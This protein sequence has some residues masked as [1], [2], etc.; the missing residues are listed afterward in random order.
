MSP[1][2]KRNKENI[3]L[4][5]RWQFK[6]G[7]YY[8]Q[9]PPGLESEWDGKK[10]FRLGKTQ[11]EAYRTWADRIDHADNQSELISALC[12]RYSMEHVP[13]LAPKSQEGYRPSVARVRAV[14]GSMRVSD[15]TPHHARKYFDRVKAAKSLGVAR[16]DITVLRGLFAK[17]ADWGYIDNHPMVGMRFEQLKAAN[18][19][20]KDWEVEAMLSITSSTRSVQMGIAYTR[21]KIMLGCR[22][23]DM[24][25]I[26][27]SDLKDDG[28]HVTPAK[29]KKSSSVQQIFRWE[30]DHGT[31]TGLR[32]VVDQ[33]LTIP[34][35]RI[36]D[37]FLFT[38]R[39]GKGFMNE[40]TGRANA[41]DSLWSRY[42][43]EVMLQTDVDRRIKEKA[44]R[45]YVGGKSKSL[46]DASDRL[47]H[48]NTAT[49]EKHYRHK[50]RIIV[51][52]T[53]NLE[54]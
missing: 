33:I 42:T 7:A 54:D 31:D 44:L 47:G 29:T 15:F 30:D 37:A 23:G 14:F 35:R 6:H 34:P 32:G 45:A 51:P 20:I 25:R 49:T 18:D 46:Q 5:K 28:I 39:Q 53:V 11:S 10:L 24:L 9:V 36:G 22:R 52:L 38:T 40:A 13:T 26:R 1:P 27:L 2:R 19:D 21:L 48:T 3:G 4:P 17:A 43:D 50:P 12:D 41:F 16:A 8:Y